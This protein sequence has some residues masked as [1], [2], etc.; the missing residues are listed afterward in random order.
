MTEKRY[1]CSERHKCTKYRSLV[2]EKI[3]FSQ[4]IIRGNLALFPDVL[5]ASSANNIWNV[6]FGYR[7]DRSEHDVSRHLCRSA[8]MMQR[9]NDPSGGALLQYPILKYFGN[10]FGYKNHIKGNYGMV[11][12]VKVGPFI[13]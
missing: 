8:L 4:E 3:L 9:A 1:G 2:T 6:M 5:Y 13:K 7:F 10:V 11:D 12:I